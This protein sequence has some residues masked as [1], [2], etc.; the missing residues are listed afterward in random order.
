MRSLEGTDS[1][2]ATEEA[3]E[4]QEIFGLLGKI[5]ARIQLIP[6]AVPYTSPGGKQ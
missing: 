5:L 4:E 6:S 3:P 1:K 2:Y